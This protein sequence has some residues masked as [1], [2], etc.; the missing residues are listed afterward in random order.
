MKKYK[1]PRVG[2]LITYI[3]F[4]IT[5]GIIILSILAPDADRVKEDTVIEKVQIEDFV[6]SDENIPTVDQDYRTELTEYW[7]PVMPDMDLPKIETTPIYI[8]I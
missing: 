8:L 6:G 2:V 5:V 7:R 4:A 3:L 1:E